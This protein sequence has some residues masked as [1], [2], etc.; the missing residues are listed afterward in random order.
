MLLTFLPQA[1]FTTASLAVTPDLRLFGFALAIS[2]LAGLTFGLAPAFASIRP[3]L[4]TALKEDTP[5]AGASRFTLR[6]G[7]W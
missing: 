6:N 3:G 7:L 2:L 1:S 4:V 5:G